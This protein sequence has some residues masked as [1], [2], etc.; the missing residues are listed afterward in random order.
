M[1]ALLHLV[2][3]YEARAA[4]V[5]LAEKLETLLRP[6]R[7]LDDDVVEHTAG[8]RHGHV[9]LLVDRGKV[10]EASHDTAVGELAVLLGR[11]QNR[12]GH[13]RAAGGGLHRSAGQLEL[14]LKQVH[15]I[16]I[17]YD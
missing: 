15:E 1:R 7:R 9:V 10:A 3:G 5:V 16:C 17:D 4:E 11:L 6:G 12:V 2:E 8:R 13:A 14:G